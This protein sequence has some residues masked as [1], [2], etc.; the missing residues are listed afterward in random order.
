VDEKMWGYIRELYTYLK[1]KY[2]DILFVIRNIY[3]S[4]LLKAIPRAVVGDQILLCGASLKELKEALDIYLFFNDTKKTAISRY[5]VYIIISGKLVVIAKD[6]FTNKIIGAELYYFN[7]RDIQ[8]KTIHQGFRG[9]LPEWQGKGFGTS[10]TN[11]AVN[12]FKKCKIDGIS[13]RVS[14][15]NIAS[16]HSNIKLGFRPIEK[17]F[18]KNMNEE[19]YYLICPFGKHD[20]WEYID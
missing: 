17:Y 10:L 7:Q 2:N 8:E 11:H 3:G 20:R 1:K 15:N 14:L 4:F 18:D 9:I 19:R 13:S 16:L 5:I 12:H 6:I